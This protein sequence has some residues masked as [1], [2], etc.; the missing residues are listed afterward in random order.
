MFNTDE[1]IDEFIP[2]SNYSMLAI[3]K[4]SAYQICIIKDNNGEC[5][6]K[7]PEGNN[8]V[9]D[10]NGNICKAT[11]C[12][13]NQY[14]IIPEGICT[15]KCDT[16]IYAIDENRKECG[17]CK[18]L[19]NEKQYK[20]IDRTE[21]LNSIP[22]NSK[23]FNDDFFLFICDNGYIANNNICVPHCYETCETCLD[24][25]TDQNNQKCLTCINILLL[26]TFILINN[27]F[28]DYP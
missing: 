23:S 3:T 24:Y 22:D 7:C 6:E 25:S 13:D 2:F 17:L 16:S 9:L 12:D 19:Y 14:L 18:D 27:Y 5:I 11:S 8:L 21:C 15:S 26:Y 1:N 4:E 20:L 10:L 28:L